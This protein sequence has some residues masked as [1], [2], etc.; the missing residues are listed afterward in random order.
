[1]GKGELIMLKL[2]EL[3][4]AYE[5]GQEIYHKARENADTVCFRT[6]EEYGRPQNTIAQGDNLEYMIYLLNE[7][8]M[9]EKL[10]LI[11]VDPPFFSGGKYQ[12]SI[13][14]ESEI[15]GKS[16]LMK[17]EAYDDKW[18][19]GMK[20]Y[21]AMLTARL[22]SMKELLAETGCIWM[23]LDWHSVHYVKLIMDQIFGADNFINEVIWTYKSGGSSKKS[24]ARKHDTLLAYG[25]SRKHKFN[26]L[27]EKSYNR[28]FKP[29]RFKGVEEFC[30]DTGWYTM[31]N[32]KDVWNIDMVGRTSSERTG[33][34]T[35]KPDKLMERIIASCSDEGD[36]CADFFAGSGTFGAVCERMNRRWIMCDNGKLA[37]AEQ[38]HRIGK[39][40]GGFAVQRATDAE[41]AGVYETTGG[42][43]SGGILNYSVSGELVN[44]ISYSGMIP[45]GA[46][47]A[48]LEKFMENDS[49]CMV[50]CW[51]AGHLGEDGVYRT[52]SISDDRWAVHSPQDVNSITVIGY[53]V[54]GNVL[55]GIDEVQEEF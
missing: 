6:E 14:L 53:D 43:E 44:L 50:K 7:K 49:L 33:Y 1:M 38:I 45:D 34:A 29:Y 12:A 51:S 23:H 8:D 18:S 42:T 19:M 25:K 15:L 31:V 24:F 48:E 26:S 16:S 30:D 22:L 35:Q 4:D 21:L 13:R 55:R 47:K 52:D 2:T 40:N 9:T 41:E 17:L 37:T 39:L 5:E 54:F 28:D 46:H 36:L 3:T 20:E 32:M 10:Q 11:Y 27:T